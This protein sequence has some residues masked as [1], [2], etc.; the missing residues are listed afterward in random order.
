MATLDSLAKKQIFGIKEVENEDTE[1]LVLNPVS[2][3]YSNNSKR[4]T[5]RLV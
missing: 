3:L 4:C 5:G 2:V 1:Q